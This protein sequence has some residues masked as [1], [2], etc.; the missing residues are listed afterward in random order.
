M[1]KIVIK[2]RRCSKGVAQGE[3]V[4]SYND[5]LAMGADI[6]RETGLVIAPRHELQGKEVGGKILV[7]P[8]GRGSTADPWGFYWLMKIGKAPKAI[9]NIKANPTTV[10]GAIISGIPMIH[11]LD[12]NPLEVIETGDIVC[13]DANKGIVEV[14]KV[15]KS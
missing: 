7:F 3:A 12:K 11:E 9:I 6:D 8:T 15:K 1:E 14:I 13:L 4:V 2:G 5:A 10:A